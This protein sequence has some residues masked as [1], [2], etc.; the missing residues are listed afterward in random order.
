MNDQQRA[1]IHKILAADSAWA[2]YALADLAP[3]YDEHC[4]WTVIDSSPAAAGVVLLFTLL[5]PPILVTVG[6]PDAVQTALAQANLPAEV[7]V[8][9]RLEHYPMLEKLYD[10]A[11]DARAMFRMK[12]TGPRNPLREP[13][14]AEQPATIRL[15][16]ADADRLRKLYAHGGP[17]T[18]DYFDPYQLENGVFIG[19]EDEAGDLAAAG[20]T[21]I[22]DWQ[23]ELATIGNMYTRS[24]HRRKGYAATIVQSLV[25]ECQ[26][27]G[28][29]NITL[30]VDQRN[31]GARRIY[32]Q[33]GFEIHCP[34]MEGRGIALRK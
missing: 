31:H 27:H 12:Q 16:Q 15:T 25:A 18:P 26:A 9:A 10:L 6:A 23:Q 1:R 8:S 22:V 32:E 19:I 17:F 21:H 30:N 28:A 4:Q 29:T 3:S 34:F 24:D 7:Y 14:N 20:G 5:Q 33:N 2:A 13:N 11:D